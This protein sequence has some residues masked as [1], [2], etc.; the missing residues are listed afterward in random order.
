MYDFNRFM[1]AKPAA[2]GSQKPTHRT[3]RDTTTDQLR[4]FGGAAAAG[5]VG[6]V[7]MYGPSIPTSSSQP[8]SQSQKDPSSAGKH[9]NGHHDRHARPPSS[10]KP[11]HAPH[12]SQHRSSSGHHAPGSRHHDA[13]HRPSGASRPDAK[14][15][16]AGAPSSSRE[17]A[18]GQMPIIL[19]PSGEL[20]ID[21]A[22]WNSRLILFDAAWQQNTM[23]SPS[24]CALSLLLLL[25]ALVLVRGYKLP[26]SNRVCAWLCMQV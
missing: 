16:A 25:P 3:E 11:Q 4:A 22:S 14:A 26:K 12:G 5:M 6:M 19:V 17:S 13:G 2:P 1:Q 9:I 8:P 15:P 24:R 21:A 10:S 20:Y 23:A 18:R 7:N